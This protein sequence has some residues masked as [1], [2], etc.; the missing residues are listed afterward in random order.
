MRH[1]FLV[2]TIV[3]GMLGCGGSERELPA[4]PRSTAS[5]TPTGAPDG[6]IAGVDGD[7][8]S[9]ALDEEE[10]DRICGEL[11]A[12]TDA[13]GLVEARCITSAYS[14]AEFSG[15]TEVEDLRQVCQEQFD[16]CVLDGMGRPA[17][18]NLCSP[19]SNCSGTVEAGVA[20]I[21]DAAE[22]LIAATAAL[23]DCDALT[24]DSLPLVHQI[25]LPPSPP[26]AQFNATCE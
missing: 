22:G 7:T 4:T 18:G 13:L 14:T 23:P 15:A 26:C 8:P 10:R 1:A 9:N 2:S 6:S 17:G 21:L 16:T 3:A 24:F 12:E 25:Q 5:G 20:C 19:T 11:G